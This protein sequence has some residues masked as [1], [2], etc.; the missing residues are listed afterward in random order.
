M[1]MRAVLEPIHGL[2][3]PALTDRPLAGIDSR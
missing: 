3:T 1:D 2:P